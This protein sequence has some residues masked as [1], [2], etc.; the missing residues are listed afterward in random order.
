MT[1]QEQIEKITERLAAALVE[2]D[3]YRAEAIDARDARDKHAE[4]VKRLKKECVELYAENCELH[5]YQRCV[6]DAKIPP[7]R[8]APEPDR[9][10][11]HNQDFQ[12]EIFG[13]QNHHID[14][15]WEI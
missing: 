13:M 15:W 7:E 12:H 11:R 10:S 3:D 14:E 9:R 2:R 1:K 8:R 4:R 6:R 5:G